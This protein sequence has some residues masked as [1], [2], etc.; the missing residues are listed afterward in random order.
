VTVLSPPLFYNGPHPVAADEELL[1]HMTKTLPTRP[2]WRAPALAGL[3]VGGVLALAG[4]GGTSPVSTTTGSAQGPKGGVDTAYKFSACMRSHGVANFPDPVVNSSPG[5][6]SVGIHIT[7]AISGSPN[8]NT[9]Q[10]ACQ[11]IMPPPSSSDLAAQA[12]QQHQKAQ[13]LL[14]FVRCLRSHGETRFP[15]PNAQG[16]LSLQTVQQDG[17]DLYAPSFVSAAKACI[18]ASNGAVTLQ[19]IEQVESSSS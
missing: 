12:K 13:D 5:S 3:L 17:V 16:H 8:F 14:S 6:Q 19:A 15:D 11:S 1:M 9:A 10:K 4:C 18:P 7:P 2:P